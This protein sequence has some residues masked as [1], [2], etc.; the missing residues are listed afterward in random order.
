MSKYV[1]LLNGPKG[2]PVFLT[3]AEDEPVMFDS[4]AAGQIEAEKNGLAMARGYL[5][6][7]WEYFES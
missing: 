1:V 4:Y 5:I 7:E 3:G 6:I 2:M